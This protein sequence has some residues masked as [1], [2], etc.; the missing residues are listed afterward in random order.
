MFEIQETN[1]Y[2]DKQ[3]LV[4]ELS[5]IKEKL[6]CRKKA[7]L[8]QMGYRETP[9][10]DLIL[11]DTSESNIMGSCNVHFLKNSNT[12]KS[13]ALIFFMENK[14]ADLDLEEAMKKIEDNVVEACKEVFG[15]HNITDNFPYFDYP[16]DEEEP[17]T[18]SKIEQKHIGIAENGKIMIVMVMGD[19]AEK[20]KVVI[21]I[22]IFN[23]KG[24]DKND[25]K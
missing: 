21:G 11:S 19:K 18:S 3:E 5:K 14:D 13:S 8:L 25:G 15:F 1:K 2:M 17:Q 20:T 24:E 10:Y 16:Q 6:L 22:S 23:R 4:T 12:V 7:L 9:F